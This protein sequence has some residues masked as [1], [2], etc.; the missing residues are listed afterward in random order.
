MGRVRALARGTGLPL[1]LLITGLLLIPVLALLGSDLTVP[2]T[3]IGDARVHLMVVVSVL[4]GGWYY[5]IDR[6]GAPFGAQLYDYPLTDYTTFTLFKGLGWLTGGDAGLVLNLTYL[7]GFLLA[8]ATAY[9]V[10]RRLRVSGPVALAFAVLYSFLPYHLER[11]LSHLFLSMYFAVPLAVLLILRQMGDAAGFF[12]DGRWRWRRD[13]LTL[14]ACVLIAT[15]GIYYTVFACALLLSAAIVRFLVDRNGRAAFSS[16][17]VLSVLGLMTVAALSPTLLYQ[18]ANGPNE[19]AVN[20][21]YLDVEVYGLRTVAMLMPIENHRIASL[22]AFDARVSQVPTPSEGGQNL[23]I[24]GSVS[25][26]GLLAYAASTMVGARGAVE[27][28]RLNHLGLLAVIALLLATVAGLGAT[29]GAF[30]FTEIR[31]WNRM[32]V[33]LAFLALAAAAVACQGWLARLRR[34]WALGAMLAPVVMLIGVLDQ[35]GAV[36]PVHRADQVAAWEGDRAFVREI[37]RSLGPGAA[38]FQL[39]FIPYPE[40]PPVLGVYDYDH[41]RGYV[42]SETLLWSYGGMKGRQPEW[43][44]RV[45]AQPVAAMLSDL[46]VAGFDG[47]YVD[48]AGYADDAGDELRQVEEQLGTGPTLSRDERL[49]FFDLRPL[50]DRVVADLH[51]A[52]LEARR[53]EVVLPLRAEFGRGFFEDEADGIAT[54]N[55]AP[56]EAALL[57]LNDAEQ[58]RGASLRFEVL[59]GQGELVIETPA[60]VERVAATPEFEPVELEVNLPPG[61]T[62]IAFD[63]DAPPLA[64]TGDPRRLVFQVRNLEVVEDV[65]ATGT[66]G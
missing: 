16:L 53:T 59:T 60:G 1:T 4:S 65:P 2:F 24:I 3:L 38:V 8:S 31:A 19:Q 54:W 30:G 49:A 50:R 41:L 66:G 20:R 5:E 13:G 40:H 17:L 18:R 63:S 11:G 39:P 62:V 37:E 33:Y 57:V 48:R 46:V 47:L 7:L 9:L 35:T 10:L 64:D 23:G 6:L 25:L 21:P 51:P 45:V 14:L 61:E 56:E 22:R 26:L 55:W 28:A 43:Q 29:L 12:G 15:T 58:T 36:D 27:R 34:G 52:D 42:H 32:V 44:A